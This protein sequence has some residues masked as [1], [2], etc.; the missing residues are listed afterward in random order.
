[1]YKIR[2]QKLRDEYD[3]VIISYSGGSDSWTTMHSFFANG[4][5]PD[6]VVTCGCFAKGFTDV[7]TETNLEA[8]IST[9]KWIKEWVIPNGVK[10]YQHDISEDAKKIIKDESW[11]HES[12]I[13][14]VVFNTARAKLFDHPRYQKMVDQGKKVCIIL[15]LEKPQMFYDGNEFHAYFNDLTH[16]DGCIR[17]INTLG[18]D[19]EMP[20]IIRFFSAGDFPLLTI[21]QSHIIKEFYK[22]TYTKKELGTL[23]T[24]DISFDHKTFRNI[25]SA[26]LY[27]DWDPTTFSRGKIH[28][29]LDLYFRDDWVR[30]REHKRLHTVMTE[31]WKYVNKNVDGYFFKNSALGLKGGLH[32]I[33]SRS[34]NLGK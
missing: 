12:S 5:L 23:L 27:K 31:G 1:L 34:Y 14:T 32:G 3:Y 7:N 28:S 26:L 10:Y 24:F 30:T 6:E 22:K 15:G 25:A 4:I 20:D 9:K 8:S 29:P 21:K 2:A 18:D 19:V 17:D 13:D 16:H 11:I 33:L